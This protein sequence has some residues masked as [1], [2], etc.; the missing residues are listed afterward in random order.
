MVPFVSTGIF[1]FTWLSSQWSFLDSRELTVCWLTWPQCWFTEG[2]SKNRYCAY[3]IWIL[4]HSSVVVRSTFIAT[5]QLPR[6]YSMAYGCY[7]VGY[8]NVRT[9][10]FHFFVYR[11]KQIYTSLATRC[12]PQIGWFARGDQIIGSFL[13]YC[14][15]YEKGSINYKEIRTL[16]NINFLTIDQNIFG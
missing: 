9:M 2:L 6:K 14:I 8:Y 16:H 3:N 15:K 10:W 11:T 12:K 1:G 4:Q 7:W 5:K 13:L